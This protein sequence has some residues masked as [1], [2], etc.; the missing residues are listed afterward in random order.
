MSGIT[1]LG[2]MKCEAGLTAHDS[3]AMVDM[4][5]SAICTAVTPAFLVVASRFSLPFHSRHSYS[6]H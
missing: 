1:E 2:L 5:L 4:V 6:I 3:D